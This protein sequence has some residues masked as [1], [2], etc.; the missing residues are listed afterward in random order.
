MLI[1][2]V[3]LWTLAHF[4]KRLLPGPRAA[5]GNAGKGLVAVAVLA[6]VLLMI[7]GYRS[8]EGE[9]LY[10]LPFNV[11]YL[12][13]IAMIFAIFLMDAG[14]AKGMVR[15]KIRHPMLTGVIIWAAAHLLVNGD[16]PSLILFGGLGLWA[17]AEILVINRAEGPW[18]P[19]EAGRW[20]SD[21]KVLGI[22]CV[23]YAVVVGIHHWLGYPVFV[24]V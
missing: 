20:S 19:P 1:A 4:F 7:F 10:A 18:T 23:I 2:G 6:S 11:W 22:A 14:R 8:A 12:N 9:F 16:T 13:N 5:L 21:L 24:L 17:I 3:L 15:T